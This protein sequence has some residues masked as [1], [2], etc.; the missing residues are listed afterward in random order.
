LLIGESVPQHPE[1]V[2]L[3]CMSVHPILEDRSIVRRQLRFSDIA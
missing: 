3:V 1:T 2:S